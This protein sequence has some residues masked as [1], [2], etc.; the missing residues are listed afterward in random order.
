M[1]R[2]PS[3]FRQIDLTRV[4]KAALAAGLDVGRIEVDTT[5]KIV[6]LARS[7]ALEPISQLERWKNT[8]A[9]TS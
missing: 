5:G 9:R 8:H 3:T 4:L 7:E 2:G 1:A 6:L